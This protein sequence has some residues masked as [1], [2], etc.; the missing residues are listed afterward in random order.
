MYNDYKIYYNN[1]VVLI[2]AKEQI[3]QNF[4][5]VM[6][7]EKQIADFFTKNCV[8]FDGLTDQDVLAINRHPGEVMCNFMDKAEI[9]IAGGGIVLNENNEVLLI[10]RK[11]KWDLPKGKIELNESIKAGA[12]R[13]V[14]EETG[15]KIA[16]VAD[17]PVVTYHAYKLKG[18][19]CLKQT[20]W[21]EMTAQPGQHQL[22]P[23]AD[24]GIDEVRWV[25]RADL[26]SYFPLCYRMVADLL[27][28]YAV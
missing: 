20:E 17:K 13:E 11:G 2:T 7:N 4:A 15:V 10:H 27:A 21:Y 25:K 26:P 5:K 3:N 24:E 23:Q 22:T 8:V 16:E 18:K 1:S 19:N 28:P 14:E 6:S 12:E 9:V